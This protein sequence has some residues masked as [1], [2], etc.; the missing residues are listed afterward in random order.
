[1]CGTLAYARVSISVFSGHVLGGALRW[2]GGRLG[3]IAGAGD[4][5][6]EGKMR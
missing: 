3:L 4:G 1:L 5:A 2:V 6:G